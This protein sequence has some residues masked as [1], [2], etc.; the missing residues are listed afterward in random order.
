MSDCG[1]PQTLQRGK[2]PPPPSFMQQGCSRRCQGPDRLTEWAHNQNNLNKGFSVKCPKDGTCNYAL[3]PIHPY[4]VNKVQ[5][6]GHNLDWQLV[7][8]CLFV[9]S[10]NSVTRSQLWEALIPSSYVRPLSTRSKDLTVRVRHCR[11]HEPCVCQPSF[12]L[13]QGTEARSAKGHVKCSQ[14]TACLTLFLI[15]I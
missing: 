4:G 3:G 1:D 8:V 11:P 2:A 12:C 5:H 15:Q 13:V 7:I 9:A 6:G 10:A 14:T